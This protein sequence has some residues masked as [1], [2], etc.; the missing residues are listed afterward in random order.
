MAT[1]DEL[2][3]ESLYHRYI[4][5]EVLALYQA[6]GRADLEHEVRVARLE[7]ARLLEQGQ[8]EAVG[9]ALLVVA[10]LVNDH[11]KATGDQASGI[12][13]GLTQILNEFGLGEADW[14]KSSGQ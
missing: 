4:E 12:V 3:P 14:D 8:H 13:A 5:A 9:K 7:V 2:E 10:K 6:G 11:R 1:E